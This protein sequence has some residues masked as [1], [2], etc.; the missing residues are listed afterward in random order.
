MRSCPTLPGLRYPRA[1]VAQ[2]SRRSPLR[3]KEP[4]VLS[5]M[6]GA[7]ERQSRGEAAHVI[8]ER[9]PC[10]GD[11]GGNM[12]AQGFQQALSGNLAERDAFDG[13]RRLRLEPGPDVRDQ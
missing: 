1:T 2:S 10:S 3:A 4:G 9:C 11:D 12:L 7:C 5:L 13:R 8:V 6:T